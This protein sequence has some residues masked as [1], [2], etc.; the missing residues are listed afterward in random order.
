MCRQLREIFILANKRLCDVL[1]DNSIALDS[2]P[3][4][5]DGTT[6]LPLPITVETQRPGLGGL[7]K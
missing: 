2:H 5:N 3:E 1:L 6:A 4:Q 7:V